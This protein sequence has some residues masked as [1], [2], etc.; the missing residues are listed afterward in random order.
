MLSCFVPDHCNYVAVFVGGPLFCG[1]LKCCN[2]SSNEQASLP[3]EIAMLS[4][5]EC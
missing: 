1:Y 3:E 5:A 2:V 4:V